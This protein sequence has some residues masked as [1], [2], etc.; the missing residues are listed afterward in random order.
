MNRNAGF[1]PVSFI[2]KTVFTLGLL[3]STS[4]AGLCTFLYFYQTR[5]IFKPDRTLTQMPEQLQLTYEEIWLPVNGDDQLHGWW[6][7]ATSARPVSVR[8]SDE[9]V[10]LYLHGN[11]ENIG[12]NLEH[13]HRYQQMGFSVFLFDY[14]GYGLSEGP[15]PSER[16]VYEDAAT[17]WAYLTEV[18]R[19]PAQ[20][21]W[22]FGHSLGG[23]WPLT[24]PK[25]SLTP[26][27]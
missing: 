16:R 20:S 26:L 18:R 27:A 23:P 19:I 17:A 10:L 11:G 7:P 1:S 22:L 6:L 5:L 14:R 8:P 24:W 3:A 21:I 2:K 12:G 4:Y 25:N 15:F 13:A 9:R